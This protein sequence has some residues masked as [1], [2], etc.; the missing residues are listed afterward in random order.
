MQSVYHVRRLVRKH[1][2][3]AILAADAIR[4]PRAQI[5]SADLR[6]IRAELQDAIRV[7]RAQISRK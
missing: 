3:Y 1:M 4:V 6:A 7:P 2:R 5:S